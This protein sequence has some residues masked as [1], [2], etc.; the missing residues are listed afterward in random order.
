ML[1]ELANVVP[2]E[3][4]LRRF[5]RKFPGFLPE[6]PSNPRIRL[7]NYAQ[8]PEELHHIVLVREEIRDM[9]SRSSESSQHLESLLLSG[10][11][12]FGV[13]MFDSPP[14]P[15]IIGVN[16]RRGEFV[17]RPQTPLQEALHYLLRNISKA[18]ICA[19]PDCPA[20]F[21]IGRRSR[22]CSTDC[23]AAMQAEAKS[24]W[25]KKSG[26]EWRKRWR[27]QQLKSRK[28]SPSTKSKH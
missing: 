12:W 10:K 25:W 24:K 4:G 6:S 27:S 28:K 26:S 8:V 20:P 7:P 21:F 14:L 11:F 18:K 13:P 17:Y 3:E 23:S 5:A 22:Y 1:T 2:N 15:G 19:N 16:W 9:W